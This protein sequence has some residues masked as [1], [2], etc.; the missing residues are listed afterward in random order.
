MPDDPEL[1]TSLAGPTQEIRNRTS[2]PPRAVSWRARTDH[3]PPRQQ[4]IQASVFDLLTIGAI[5]GG[6][7]HRSP[8]VPQESPLV[9]QLA[10]CYVRRDTMASYV[11]R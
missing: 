11:S 2:A 8:L 7:R 9:N 10:D 6:D 5:L 3:R 4:D 1:R